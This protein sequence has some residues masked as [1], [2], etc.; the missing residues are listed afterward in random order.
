MG[1]DMRLVTVG[2]LAI[3]SILW[4]GLLAN[5][6][7]KGC[8]VVQT[9]PDAVLYLHKAPANS[10]IVTRLRPGDFLFVDTARCETEGGLSICDKGYPRRWTHV[11]SVS[12]IDKGHRTSTTGW[13]R[14]QYVQWVHCEEH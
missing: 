2:A 13:I 11:T 5:A 14:N 6:A 4:S 7:V 12:R 9:A 10:E 8:A 3:I 1:D